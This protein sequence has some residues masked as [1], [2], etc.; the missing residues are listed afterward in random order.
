[1]VAVGSCRDVQA[2]L[3]KEM[4][5]LKYETLDIFLFRKNTALAHNRQ[6]VECP[7]CLPRLLV[8]I[9]VVFEVGDD[10]H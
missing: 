8:E 10:P 1:M 4:S 9:D 6:D 3:L 2:P 5:R 7:L